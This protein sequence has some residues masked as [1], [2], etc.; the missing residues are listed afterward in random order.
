MKKILNWLKSSKSDFS[1]FIILL[2]LANLVA[3]NA[4]ARFDLTSA[5]SYTLSKASK[6]LVKNL[7]EPLSVRV[8][9]DE[10]LPAPYNSVA[11]YLNDLLFEYKNAANKNFT[12][13]YMDMDKSE[14]QE[15]ASSLGLRAMQI[16]EVKNKEIGFK[17]GYMGLVITYGDNIELMDGITSTDGLEYNIT[18]KITKM[19]N[20]A[21]SL[22]AIKN[23]K[24]IAATLYFSDSL[25]RLQI[26]GVDQL[27]KY[28][29]D[30]VAAVNKKNQ[31]CLDF[32]VVSPSSMEADSLSSQFGLQKISFKNSAG[33]TEYA[34][35]GFVLQ[36]EDN[37]KLIPVTIQRSFFGYAVDGLDELDTT[38]SEDLQSLLSKGTVMGYITGHNELDRTDETYSGYLDKAISK[39]Y[40]VQDIDLNSEDIP[41]GIGTI[42]ING[43][44]MDYTE[45]ELYK[46]DQFIMRGGNVMFFI[47]GMNQDGTAQYTGGPQFVPNALNLDR[48]LTAYGIDRKTNIVFDNQCFVNNQTQYG[49][50]KY[51]WAPELQKNQL[52]KKNPITKNLGYVYMFQNGQ[53]D[54]SKAKENTDVKVTVLAKSSDEAWTMS[55]NIFLN[56]MAMNPPSQTQSYDLVAILEGKFSSAFESAPVSE[57]ENQDN[58]LTTS[59]HLSSSIRPGKIFIANSSYITTRNVI[60]ET[61]NTPAA[62]F[63]LNA[64]DY[65]NGNVDL[66]TMRSKN[67]S[68]NTLNIKSNGAALFWKYFN[69]IGLAILVAVCG[70]IVWR[71]R[72]K[73]RKAINAKYNPN[74]SRTVV[75]EKK[76]KKGE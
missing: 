43:P 45:E 51:Y 55:E 69:E 46:I 11:Q 64:V 66:C 59:N 54:L 17:S 68:A 47:D 6:N 16:Q 31:D 35:L 72:S 13:S 42:M 21:S 74:D 63:I 39:M 12:V 73:R 2:I 62:M 18:S 3:Y 5:Q 76:N 28:V 71:M 58:T 36:Y 1:L 41:S 22:S 60:N 7:E 52:A 19:I 10:N 70:F 14:N 53:L 30:S 56:P 26:G 50:L 33:E 34:V 67:L 23:G 75:K 29:R 65:M 49:T 20:T 32:N 48:L 4:F 15:L 61:A 44:Q 40:K 24:K 8:F 25:K 38:I 9:F 37:F 57:N 27:E